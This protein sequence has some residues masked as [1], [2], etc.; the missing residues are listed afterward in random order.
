MRVLKDDKYRSILKVARKEFIEKGFKD[1]SMRD[2]ARDAKVGLSNI[3]NYFRNKDEIFLA[4]VKPAKD[5]IF[6]FITERHTEENLDFDNMSSFGYQEEIIEAYILLLD[7]YREEL[8]LLLYHS[9]GSSMKDFRDTFTDHIT[10]VTDMHMHFV[11]KRYPHARNI[12]SFFNHAQ[13]SFMVSIIGEI[14]SHR[15][16]KQ[17]IREFFRE[18]FKFEIAGWRELTGI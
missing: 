2:I 18:Y 1:A 10:C 8:Y 11:M 7:R 3:Y 16:S 6:S 17:K 12:S 4:I 13:S 14:I 5:E 9:Q 15:L